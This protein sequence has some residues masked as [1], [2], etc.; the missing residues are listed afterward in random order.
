MGLET[1]AQHFAQ[2]RGGA[3]GNALIS[4]DIALALQL[5]SHGTSGFR[6]VRLPR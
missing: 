5:P 1:G 4:K 6:H 3:I 2:S